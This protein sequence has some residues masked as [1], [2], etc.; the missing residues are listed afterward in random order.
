MRKEKYHYYTTLSNWLLGYDRYR[1]TFEK[2]YA[3]RF[4][5]VFYLSLN[6]DDHNFFVDKVL[7]RAKRH[8]KVEE[9]ERSREAQGKSQEKSQEKSQAGKTSTRAENEKVVRIGLETETLEP[10]VQTGTGVGHL[11]PRNILPVE[12]LEIL[13]IVDG[14]GVFF[15]T[16]P[17]ELAGMAF[18]GLQKNAWQECRPRSFSVLPI[19]KACNASCAFCFSKA[20]VSDIVR[21]APLDMEKIS[22]MASLAQKKGAKRAVITGGGEPLLLKEEKMLGLI[23]LLRQYFEKTLLITNGSLL[24]ERNIKEMKKAGLTQIALSRHGQD[25][26]SDAEVMGLSVNGQEKI[27]LIRNEGLNPRLICVMQKGF[28]DTGDKILQYIE[29]GI[30]E[31]AH[32]F[33]FKELYVS[34]TLESTFA[35]KKENLYCRENQVPLSTGIQML[36]DNGFVLKDSLPWGSPVY[37]KSIRGNEIKV[38]MYTEPSVGWELHN[39]VVRSWNFLSDNRCLASLE[40]RESEIKGICGEMGDEPRRI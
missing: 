3:A 28:I 39:G 29:R 7:E 13:E 19:A 18:K 26:K 24:N 34:S 37:G 10:N 31:G 16:T 14:K 35:A 30:E 25:A 11:Y 5:D 1:K 6:G 32:E 36:E 15:E 9:N 40:D 27:N 21:Q 33:C 17:E 12:T 23:V 4:K 22:T 2:K 8:S 20:S 38:A